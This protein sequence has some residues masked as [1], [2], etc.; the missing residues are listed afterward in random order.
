MNNIK[1]FENFNNQ[2]IFTYIRN[3]DIKSV[4]NYIDSGYDLNIKNYN[5]YS[6]LIYACDF[7][8]TKIEIVKLLL[9][10]DVDVNKQ[11]NFGRTALIYLSINNNTE[12]AKLLLNAGA[13]IDKQDNFGYTPLM[14][15]AK[16]DN[17][18]FI[19][20]LINFGVDLNKQNNTG[21]TAL[22]I[23]IDNNSNESIKILLDAGADIDKQ[24]NRGFTALIKAASKNNRE[25]VELLLDYHADEF[26]LN[27]Y[28]FS[29]YDYLNDK[30]EKYFLKEYPNKVY[31]AISHNYKKSF[32]EF[33]KEYNIK[34]KK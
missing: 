10:Y 25:I 12:I 1:K 23:A 7:Y 24:N 31:N 11:D 8:L 6:P 19:K 21:Y 28:N 5:G 34:I 22:I 9:N 26:I 15:A 29:F 4:K 33:V 14:Y 3:D 27:D 18:E 32:I 13:D 2:D 30:N 20:L 17:V 16:N